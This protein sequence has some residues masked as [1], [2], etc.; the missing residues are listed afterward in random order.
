MKTWLLASLAIVLFLIL[1]GGTFLLFR[2]PTPKREPLV[3]TQD[4]LVST[5]QQG[6]FITTVD[7][8]ES[9]VLASTTTQTGSTVTTNPSGRAL[10]EIEGARSV[11]DYNTVTLLEGTSNKNTLDL[12][13]G[14]IWSHVQKILGQGEFYKIQT[15]NAVAVVRGTSFGVSYANVTTT[16]VVTEGTVS[17]LSRD[18]VTGVVDVASEVKVTAGQKAY[19]VGTGAIIVEQLSKQDKLLPWFV[20]NNTAAQPVVAPRVPISPTPSSGGSSQPTTVSVSPPSDYTLTLSSLSPTTLQQ[21][22]TTKVQITGSGL[23]H[24]DALFVG[25]ISLTYQIINDAT[26]SASVGQV[27]AGVYDVQA[28]DTKNRTML[29]R[30]A[31]TITAPP[32][33]TQTTPTAVTKP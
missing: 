25:G 23:T 9:E 22:A 2:L 19:R 12:R 20:F 31:L 15:Q 3:A 14:S 13:T 11:L 18:P 4:A 33:G 27:P 32:R 28:V 26:V 1:I 17:F 30:Q 16:L 7:S 10:V 6:V 21:G 29:L 5:L 24:L 8:K